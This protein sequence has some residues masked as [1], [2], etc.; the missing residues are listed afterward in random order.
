MNSTNHSG[1][2]SGPIEVSFDNL[3]PAILQCFVIILGGYIAGRASIITSTQGKGIGSFV[4]NFCLPA[5]LFKS[6]CELNFSSVNWTFLWSILIAKTFV[7]VVVVLVTLVVKR[8]L[9]LGYAGLN[10]IF[11]TQS[12]DFAL[13]YPI[14]QALYQNNHPE[15]LQYIYLVAPI[16]LVFL[17]P[18]GFVLMEIHKRRTESVDSTHSTRRLIWHVFK[19]IIT[20]PIVFMT[21]IGIAGNFIFKQHVPLILDDILTVLGNAFS[22]AALF[23]LGLS[24]VGKVKSLTGIA[25]LGPV[26]LIGAK[27]LL[28]PLITWEVIGW[29]DMQSK[30]NDSEALSMYGF[31]YGTFPTAPSVF[32]YAS[33]YGFGQDVIATGMVAGTFISAP[34]MFVSAKMMTVVVN[35][36]MD[37]KALLL[38]TNFDTS[39]VSTICCV[40]VM[41]VLI[42]SGKWRRVPHRFTLCLVFSQLVSC[43]GMLMY[44]DSDKVA[45]WKDYLQITLLL[46]G[47]FSTR[48]WTAMVSVALC[49][50]HVRGLCFLLRVQVWLIFFGFGIPFLVVGVL[51]L[52]GHD[53]MVH[54]MDPSFHMGQV[55]MILGPENQHRD[56]AL[57]M[58]MVSILVLVLGIGISIFALVIRQ[59]NDRLYVVESRERSE[60][61][62]A[63]GSGIQQ[64]EGSA[65][66]RT[67]ADSSDVS[68][69]NPTKY[70]ACNGPVTVP[71]I[72]D[73]IPFPSSPKREETGSVTS[74]QSQGSDTMLFPSIDERT[75]LVGRCNTTQKRQCIGR[76]RSYMTKVNVQ[77]DDPQAE[78]PQQSYSMLQEEY[79]TGHHLVLLLL[80][81]LSMF[82]G[83]FLCV[84]RLFNSHPTGI[85]I[86]IEF[87]DGVFNYGQGFLSFAVFGFDTRLMFTP[88]IRR[89]IS[90]YRWINILYVRA[91][92]LIYGVEIVQLP[93]RDEISEETKLTCDQFRV[94]H[95]ENC[96][97]QI[98]KDQ[99]YRLRKYR[100]V[101]IGH[102]LCDWLMKAGVCRDRGEC[103][104][105]GRQL[106]LGRCIAHVTGE[107]HF[108]D[109]PYFYKFLN[110]E[111]YV[112]C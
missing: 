25:L 9:N 5:L 66:K 73:I 3:Y 75:C 64:T 103:V 61:R 15:Y 105:Y 94:Y 70:D 84:W 57:L 37:Y 42:L 8:P 28:L 72:E 82:I 86:E 45:M 76:L 1:N 14:L 108:H 59:R 16:S 107:H 53:Q 43:V 34:L 111:E 110:T 99:R 40:W 92:R 109:L 90:R 27:S 52:L 50:L 36:E 67:P 29:L 33:Q 100:N 112:P 71:S 51:F 54:E 104:T 56:L 93:K 44:T 48:T 83:L 41:G 95:G 96:E 88:I 106:V 58:S 98:V 80:L 26:L 49:L 87:L 78:E 23:Y 69:S 68:N 19:G 10:G 74:D 91:R 24:L 30:C 38:D 65:V 97:K 85:Y 22:A 18:L 17:N 2:S 101:F 62:P 32:L 4:S 77:M 55:Q 35:N 7:F 12:N 81:I 6:M 13:G 39:I 46:L 79:Q 102:D 47:V 20:N 89:Y 21:A 11:S 31:L 63:T 60:G